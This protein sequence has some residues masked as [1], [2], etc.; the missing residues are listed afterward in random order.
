MAAGGPGAGLAHAWPTRSPLDMGHAWV[1]H[2]R[3]PG[4]ACPSGQ[5]FRLIFF[6][7]YQALPMQRAGVAHPWPTRGSP[8]T[9]PDLVEMSRLGREEFRATW[10][11]NP[12]DRPDFFPSFA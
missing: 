8:V 3:F 6:F 1:A 2:T 7:F 10:M 5:I 9:Q 12:P 4:H 11:P